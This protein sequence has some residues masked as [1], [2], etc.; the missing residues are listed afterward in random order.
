MNDETRARRRKMD[1]VLKTLLL[2]LLGCA[3]AVADEPE[4][5]KRMNQESCVNY[6]HD[7]Q[8][9]AIYRDA[10]YK[11]E[12]LQRHVEVLKGEWYS[13]EIWPYVANLIDLTYS[14]SIHPLEW[15]RKQFE[16]C[17]AL[18]GLRLSLRV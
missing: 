13:E 10:G 14:S 1:I 12:E 6:A 7:A 8:R 9:F 18:G 11:K 3:L 5:F 4:K 17:S 15:A 2:I 16:E